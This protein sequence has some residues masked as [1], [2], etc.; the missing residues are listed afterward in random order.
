MDADL[1]AF[2]VTRRRCDALDVAWAPAA[3]DVALDSTQGYPYLLQATGKHVWDV[4]VRS[5][6]SSEDAD[7]GVSAARAE[8]DDDL[9]RS[10]WE[11]ATPRQRALLRAIA[12]FGRVGAG[13]GGRPGP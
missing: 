5:P 12:T 11:R 4:A 1:A 13:R 2:D 3:L 6:I 8:V 10:R 9:Y 7:L